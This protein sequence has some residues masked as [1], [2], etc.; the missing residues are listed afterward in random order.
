MSET[1]TSA[2]GKAASNGH[3]NTTTAKG[4]SSRRRAN[5]PDIAA[6]IEQAIKLRTALH[7]QQIKGHISGF[8]NNWYCVSSLCPLPEQGHR[9][10]V[11]EEVMGKYAGEVKTSARTTRTP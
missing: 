9:S 8:L 7:D 10:R 5:Q 11:G 1:T 4:R 3:A 6:L 2:N